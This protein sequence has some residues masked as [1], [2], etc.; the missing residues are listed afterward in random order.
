MATLVET[1]I[2]SYLTATLWAE[3]GKIVRLGD[4]NL[5]VGVSRAAKA[6]S[7]ANRVCFLQHSEDL[8]PHGLRGVGVGVANKIHAMLSATQENVN[9]VICLEE[10]DLSFFV[11]PH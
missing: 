1:S 3:S 8:A 10:S 4:L 9:A 11:A 5:C 7:S 6:K 2:A